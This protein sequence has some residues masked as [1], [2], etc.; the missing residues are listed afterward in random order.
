MS[1]R[2]KLASRVI[3]AA[4][5]VLIA[6]FVS[7]PVDI[8]AALGTGGP[9]G[10]SIVSNRPAL[11]TPSI[12]AA[13]SSAVPNQAVVLIGSGFGATSVAGGTGSG[14]R[15][16]ITGTG[17]SIITMGGNTLQ[18]PYIT[19]PIDLDD[20]GSWVVELIIEGNSST[21]SAS[22]LQFVAKDTGGA[23]ATTSVNLVSRKISIDDSD[24]RIGTTVKIKG[25]GFPATNV[26][27]PKSFRV[28]IQYGSNNLT[29]VTPDTDGEFEV[30][31]IVPN[32]AVIP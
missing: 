16:Q 18:S 26:T 12:S 30:D 24:S 8:Q 27:S 22:S 1:I 3:L 6:G 21:F 14:G 32:S 9:M 25:V 4:I 20:G 7:G 13:P 31:F 5:A 29:S 23:T 2:P 11:L 10:A 19:Y 15:H 17:A 28:N